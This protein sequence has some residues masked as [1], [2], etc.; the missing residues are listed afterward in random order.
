MPWFAPH[1]QSLRFDVV[2]VEVVTCSFEAVGVLSGIGVGR[3]KD[4]WSMPC[5]PSTLEI[6]GKQ[7]PRFSVETFVRDKPQEIAP[8]ALVKRR[9]AQTA[10][11]ALR[12]R[13]GGGV[14][15]GVMVHANQ[16]TVLENGDGG[17]VV[18]RQAI[19]HVF[20]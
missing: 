15:N 8:T 19:L 17:A 11:T 12:Q 6:W 18:G 13:S 14:C 7:G 10:L 4:K 9:L 3:T 16:G 1:V 20:V 2:D 5:A